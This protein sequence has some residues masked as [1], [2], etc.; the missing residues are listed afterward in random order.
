M[1]LDHPPASPSAVDC[2]ED[3]VVCNRRGLH[4]RASARFVHRA[5]GF[6]A[7][8][9]VCRNDRCV[10]GTSIMGLM[11]LAATPGTRLSI[12]AT[13]PDAQQAVESLCLLIANKFDEE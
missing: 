13:G 10:P 6:A 5:E 3:A 11:M 8:I 4:A 9:T 2:Q 7:R 12:S 1:P